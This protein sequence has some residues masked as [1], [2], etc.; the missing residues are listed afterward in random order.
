[1]NLDDIVRTAM[2]PVKV[3]DDFVL[4]QYTKAVTGYER[5]G[6]SRYPL[7]FATIPLSFFSINMGYIG[8]CADPLTRTIPDQ[9]HP[10]FVALTLGGSLAVD[11]CRTADEWLKEKYFGYGDVQALEITPGHFDIANLAK[12]ISPYIRFSLFATAA[13]YAGKS[14]FDIYGAYKGE[15]SLSDAGHTFQLALGIL[16]L[17]SS[18][19]IKDA[20][21]DILKK[22]PVWK[23]IYHGIK[24]YVSSL[25]PQPIPVPMP[26]R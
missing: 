1:M 14:V 8:L 2:M 4:R 5:K 23:E 9:Y 7:A 17:S 18:I 6:R 21:K 15:A 19:Y 13:A 22:D 25:L 3:A 12:K 24:E 10:P 11:F 26:V 16:S 20:N